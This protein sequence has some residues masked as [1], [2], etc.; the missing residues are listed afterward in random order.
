MLAVIKYIAIDMNKIHDAG[1]GIYLD[2]VIYNYEKYRHAHG[3]YPEV[4]PIT[5]QAIT[6]Y[7]TLEVLTNKANTHHESLAN[8]L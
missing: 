2:E 8:I 7:E 4:V 5:L 3:K 6:G 1:T